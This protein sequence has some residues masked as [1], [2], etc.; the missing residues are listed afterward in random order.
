[1]AASKNPSCPDRKE[2]VVMDYGSAMAD[3][4]RPVSR[5]SAPR[6]LSEHS[7]AFFDA[8]NSYYTSV[9]FRS[10]VGYL[11]RGYLSPMQMRVIYGHISGARRR[12]LNSRY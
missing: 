1:M 12:G 8:T 4:L 9:S 5:E 3:G 7:P 10:V 6:N 11:W 2:D